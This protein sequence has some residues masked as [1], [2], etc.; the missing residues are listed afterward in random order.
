D[1]DNLQ[2]ESTIIFK[3]GGVTPDNDTEFIV[4]YQFDFDYTGHHY[5]II[6]MGPTCG[7]VNISWITLNLSLVENDESYSSMFVRYIDEF[8]AGESPNPFTLSY[9]IENIGSWIGNFIII[10]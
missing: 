4:Y 1:P 5:G 3:V 7:S 9:G 6:S 8:T 10:A 2:E